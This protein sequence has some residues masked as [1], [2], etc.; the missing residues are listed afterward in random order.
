MK[1][2]PTELSAPELAVTDVPAELAPILERVKS[3]GG[4][5]IGVYR[6]PL[7]GHHLALVSLPIERVGPTPFQR[8]VSDSHVRKLTHAME[9]DAALPRSAD[10][11]A[12]AGWL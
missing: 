4:A 2:T 10:H 6:E 12:A 7:G 3:D 9:Q 5:V 1:L 11:R 8:D